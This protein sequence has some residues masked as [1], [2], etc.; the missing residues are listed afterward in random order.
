MANV[1]ES[2]NQEP[3]VFGNFGKN[4]IT[5]YKMPAKYQLIFVLP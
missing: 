3:D 1:G 2:K 4:L 5:Y